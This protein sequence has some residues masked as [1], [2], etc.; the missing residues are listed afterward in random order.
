VAAVSRTHNRGQIDQNVGQP[1]NPAAESAASIQTKIPTR[2]SLPMLLV[3][4]LD[5]CGS[6]RLRL[7]FH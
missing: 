5:A 2:H 4:Q 6:M 3:A 7:C 1:T